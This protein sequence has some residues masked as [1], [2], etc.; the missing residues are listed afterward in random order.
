MHKPPK[1]VAESFIRSHVA[2]LQ[3]QLATILE[4]LGIQH[5]NLL[6]KADNKDTMISKME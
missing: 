2:S 5:L 3:P 4:K 6:A 1:A